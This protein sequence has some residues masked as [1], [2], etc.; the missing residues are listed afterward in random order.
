MENQT[1]TPEELQAQKD[2]EL[3]VQKDTELKPVPYERF[4]EINKA[5]KELEV[6]L[7][8]IIDK[9][10]AD[11]KAS[12]DS[13]LVDEGNYK[14]LIQKV[15]TD[16]AAEK[17][18]LARMITSTYKHALA[19]E[20]GLLKPEYIDLFKVDIQTTDDLEI[21]NVKDVE[22]AFLDWK[23]ENPILFNPDK[24]VVKTDSV[25]IIRPI[26]QI[27]PQQ[28][29]REEIFAIGFKQFREKHPA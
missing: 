11:K 19:S 22:K 27:D 25:P 21:K 17:T 24:K 1:A 20:Y 14:A 28:M 3:K 4:A 29:T 12:E 23:K 2:A 5:K 8:S 16:R 6:K 26:N 9:Q 10:V 7:Q 13:K 15:E 18:K